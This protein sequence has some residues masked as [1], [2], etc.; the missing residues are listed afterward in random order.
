MKNMTLALILGAIFVAAC[1]DKG[2]EKGAASGE[3]K[4]GGGDSIGVAECDDYFKK[5][6]ACIGK[7]PAEGKKMYEDSMKQN[8]D[9]WKAAASGPGKDTL[10]TACKAATDAIAQ[11][12][13]CK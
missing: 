9:A 7:M 12:P 13:N 3:A 5:M 10:K 6:E 8:R 2:G 11:M 1:G 4:S